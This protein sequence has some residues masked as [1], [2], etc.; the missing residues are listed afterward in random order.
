MMTAFAPMPTQRCIAREGYPFL[1][2]SAAFAITAFVLGWVVPGIAI[3]LLFVFIVYF[4]RNPERV[5]PQDSGL[6]LAPAD[7]RIIRI[8]TVPDAPHLGGPAT[9]V[10][11]FM[12][13]FNVH[14]NRMPMRATIE[15][16]LYRP[17]KFFVASL[18][19]ACKHNE[20]NTLVLKDEGGRRMAMTQI[21]GLVARRIVCYM[22]PGDSRNAGD[23]FGLI[24][25]GSRVDLYLPQPH[26]VD[27]AVGDR[28]KGGSSVIGRWT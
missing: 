3:T 21:A 16:V 22:R 1:F 11:I 17:G 25:F 6:I 20:Q 12:S 9:K 2:I 10:S 19:K 13:V 24:R 5:I 18:D 23:R 14:I 27:I 4:F 26:S 28:V 7:G 15:K 8:E